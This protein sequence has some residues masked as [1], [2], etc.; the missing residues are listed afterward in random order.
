LEASF[1]RLWLRV[2]TPERDPGAPVRVVLAD[3]RSE[4]R[5][6]V[7]I[8]LELAGGFDIVGEAG[9]GTE[10]IAVA[11]EKQPDLLLLDVLMPGMTGLEAMPYIA[12]V[13]PRTKVVILTA[14]DTAVLESEEFQGAT[15]AFDK[16]IGP[17]R[18]VQQLQE[19]FSAAP[20]HN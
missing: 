6:T 10:A 17:S 16:G 20:A 14:I 1:E 18:L 5:A 15:A 4:L 13:A 19:L 8:A 11:R 7:R 9:T 3:D 2:A 12:N